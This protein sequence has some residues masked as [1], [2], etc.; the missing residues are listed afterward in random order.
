MAPMLTARGGVVVVKMTVNE[1]TSPKQ[2]N[3]L[4]SI[5]SMEIENPTSAFSRVS[6]DGTGTHPQ[7]GYGDKVSQRVAV[8]D[9]E[10]VTVFARTHEGANK[11]VGRFL[12]I[13]QPMAG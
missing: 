8:V 2:P 10:G 11:A 7:A 4:Y 6:P 3:P 9:G 5:E 12:A 13:M 1:T